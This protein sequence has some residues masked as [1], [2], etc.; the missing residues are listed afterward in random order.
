[1]K[2]GEK[3]Y[4]YE[5][6]VLTEKGHIIISRYFES[7]SGVNL[8]DTTLS[9]VKD[10]INLC[11]REQEN[12]FIVN[13]KIRNKTV[14]VLNL[15]IIIKDNTIILNDSKENNIIL[16]SKLPIGD[17]TPKIRHKVNLK[18]IIPNIIKTFR[19]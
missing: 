9:N 13:K 17:Y 3:N 5:L 1:M 15:N 14:G 8:D 16:N 10:L 11:L 2:K 6:T 12:N 19:K 18:P 7:N 4:R